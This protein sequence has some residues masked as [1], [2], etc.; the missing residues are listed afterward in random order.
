MPL[1]NKELLFYDHE[2]LRLP[3]DKRTEYH[4]QVDRLTSE[5]SASQKDKAEIKITRIVKAGSFAKHTILRKTNEDPVDVD[6][7]VYIDGKDVDSENYQTL[8]DTIYKLLVKQYP[9]KK[10]KD[11][12]LQRKA[13]TVQFIGSGLAVDIVPVIQI[14]TMPDYGWQYDREDGSR[15]LTSAPRQIAFVRDRKEKYEHFR[16]LV[17]LA[18]RWNRRAEVPGL[19]SFHIELIL[20]WLLDNGRLEGS[21]EERFRAFLLFLHQDELKTRIDFIE[22]VKNGLPEDFDHPVIIVDPV[23]N[24]NNTASRIEEDERKEIAR[25]AGESW[26]TAHLASIDN[27]DEEWKEIF[28]P[29]FRTK[30]ED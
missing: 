2:V 27:D 13:A 11:F 10:V 1:S 20:G 6:V 18:K 16:T 5:L 30:E 9:N 14:P 19:R 28:G 7:V 24:A 12:D 8:G 26:E 22:N 23:S 3:K 15:S 21:I 29:G 25:I 17:R 4:E